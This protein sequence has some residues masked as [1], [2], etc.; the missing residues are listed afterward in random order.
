MKQDYYIGLDVGTESVGWAVTDVD[1]NLVKKRGQDYWGVYLFDEAKTAQGRRA[2]RTNRRRL[3]RVRH[4]LNL[5][6][7]L[8]DS[9]ISAKDFGFFYRLE[10]SKYFDEDKPEI[11]RGKF[12]LFN[13]KDF[14]DKEYYKNYPT[15]FHLRNALRTQEIK[16]VRLLYLAVH[17]ILKNRGHFLFGE[18]DFNVNDASDVS[19]EFEK[20]NRFLSEN[21]GAGFDREKIPEIFEM[22]CNENLA[23]R[24]R[25]EKILELAGN[26]KNKLL[27]EAVNAVVGLNF[28]CQRCLE[29]TEIF[30]VRIKCRSQTVL[31]KKILQ[32]RKWRWTTTKRIFWRLLKKY[33]QLQA[34]A[35]FCTERSLFPK[36][37]RKLTKPT[38]E[39]CPS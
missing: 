28:R 4:R 7:E 8:F 1:Y 21:D 19:G 14:G 38:A 39:I 33:S 30:R 27:G 3:A 34:C 29:K 6:Q 18:Q 13:D 16:D 11:A 24:E 23:K 17:H 5:L 2:F 12:L 37:K 25:K 31:L 15:I 32:R 10:N 9:E 22:L 26:S 36:Q 35:I 20:I